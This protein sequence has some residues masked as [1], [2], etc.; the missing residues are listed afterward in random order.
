MN[1]KV[2]LQK[3]SLTGYYLRSK[4]N[5]HR[6]LIGKIF[7]V[8]IW[9]RIFLATFT[10]WIVLIFKKYSNILNNQINSSHGS[11]LSLYIFLPFQS[12][13]NWIAQFTMSTC[14]LTPNV[15]VI[16]CRT[17]GYILQIKPINWNHLPNVKL[18]LHT[19]KLIKLS[20]LH[21]LDQSIS[22]TCQ[23]WSYFFTLTNS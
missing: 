6:N 16:T 21:T 20:W 10:H 15:K 22:I 3:D 14:H 1:K 17:H 11:T 8:A 19:N 7:K 12:Q 13:R 9:A 5:V 2:N 18:F 4:L 23:M